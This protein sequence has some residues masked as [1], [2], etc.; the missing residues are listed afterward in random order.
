MGDAAGSS[1]VEL[2]HTKV[3]CR[4]EGPMTDSNMSQVEE[5]MLQCKVEFAHQFGR[6]EDAAGSV[7]ALE[8]G[9]PSNPLRRSH[10]TVLQEVD[11]EARIRNALLPALNLAEYPKCVVSV[12]LMVLQDDGSVVSSCLVAASLALADARVDMYD[13]VTSCTVVSFAD[14]TLLADPCSAEVAASDG[15]LV[16]AMM[17]SWKEVTLWQQSGPAPTA[18]VDLCRDGCRTLYRFMRQCLVD[19][20]ERRGRSPSAT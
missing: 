15:S 10:S 3:L 5:G 4:V 18:A 13:L 9:G 12:H 8:G 6:V 20:E 11:M 17:P 16:L 7:S 1:L 19:N 14:E 2:G